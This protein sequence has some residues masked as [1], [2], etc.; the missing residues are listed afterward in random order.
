MSKARDTLFPHQKKALTKLK[1]ALRAPTCKLVL[2]M[3]TGA[4]KTKIAVELIRGELRAKNQVCFTVPS[5]EL[6][7]Q[8]YDYL[9]R[10]GV[11][12]S[13]IGVQRGSDDRANDLAPIQ[14]CSV[15]TISRRNNLPL[16]DLYIV[17][18]CHIK[19]EFIDEAVKASRARFLGLTAT[20]WR[21]YLGDV[22]GGLLSVTSTEE[23][24]DGGFLSPYRVF[25]RPGADLSKVRT[26]AGDYHLRE[27]SDAMN[28]AQKV[29]ADI[30][31]NWKKHGEDRP[32][33]CFCVTKDHATTVRRKFLK[34]GIP[35]GYVDDQ[36]PAKER[37][38]LNADF[39]S[40][41]VKVIC[42]VGVLTTGIDWDVR[43]II[44]GR[45]TKSKILFVQIIGRGLRTA[46]GKDDCL[47]FD[48]TDAHIQHGFVS[49]I[50]ADRLH[51]K[52]DH[53]AIF[54]ARPVN[55]LKSC[56]NCGFVQPIAT[57][58]CK[59]CGH[60]FAGSSF[61]WRGDI[62][63]EEVGRWGVRCLFREPNNWTWNRQR[64]GITYRCSLGGV[65]TPVAAV[66]PLADMCNRLLDEGK[67]ISE[68]RSEISIARGNADR[69][70]GL[71][72][73]KAGYRWTRGTFG[74]G[75][76]IS[77]R[78][79]GMKDRETIDK[80]AR[81]CNAEFDAG[82]PI[83][84]IK[85]LFRS[86]IG[87]RCFPVDG[88]RIE[89]GIYVWKKTRNGVTFSKG[90]GKIDKTEEK[91]VIRRAMEYLL[92]FNSGISKEQFRKLFAVNNRHGIAG[93]F[94]SSRGNWSWERREIGSV[95]L[96]KQ[97]P[98]ETAKRLAS[99]CNDLFDNGV[100]IEE[101][102]AAI[103]KEKARAAK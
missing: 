96:G 100:S 88:L 77:M 64:D 8:T 12:K 84:E 89:S 68:I 53:D 17:D 4:R 62:N 27:L 93:I 33:F 43:C 103:A 29:T 18:E 6:A 73:D 44:F 79:R 31:E 75:R 28:G 55:P 46:K 78:F 101:I 1:T 57:R 83:K 51:K 86:L 91:K 99:I 61:V 72:L 30:V 95:N 37:E 26:L 67:T 34:A 11:P 15:Q 14:V 36:T 23:L 66:L 90:F 59:K 22:Y 102:R 45:P 98:T 20:P 48:H 87:I 2:A 16:A 60:A 42:N 85:T 82:K 92:A 50:R 97:I 69:I 76:C 74:T 35:C 25:M 39:H 49:D 9:V 52:S 40:G 41:K 63:L 38:K 3:P 94:R 21:K 47:I 80:I 7:N 81:Q 5:I 56:D 24:I 13:K 10:E 65:T 71:V 19:S 32:T 58:E 54:G 70:T